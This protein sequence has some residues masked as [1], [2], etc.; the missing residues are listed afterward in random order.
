[1]IL[2][3]KCLELGLPEPKQNEEQ[4]HFVKR[5]IAEGNSLNT[6]VCRY[7]GI[8]NLHSIVPKL[9]KLGIKFEWVNSP[10]YCPLL[11]ITPPEP[12]IVI[13]MTMEQ[14]KEYWEAKKKP[15]K[16]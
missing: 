1:M 8:H 11:E 5:V 2:T 7:I 10:V 12:V 4:L 14:Q 16:S 15:A 6:R 13:Y 3:N 9:F